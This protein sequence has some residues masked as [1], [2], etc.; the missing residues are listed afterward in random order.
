MPSARNNPENPIKPGFIG[1]SPDNGAVLR[2]CLTVCPEC[3]QKMEGFL[4]LE[5]DGIYLRRNCERHGIT[6]ISLSSNPAGYAELDRFYFRTL[7]KG[8]TSG[9]I[10]NYWILSTSRCQMMCDYCQVNVREPAFEE[11]DGTDLNRVIT[12][13]P[14]IKLTMSGGEPTLHPD[15]LRFFRDGAL[16]GG[17]TQLATNG[18]ALADHAFCSRLKAAGAKEVRLSV[19]S[20]SPVPESST[21]ASFNKYIP[22]KMLALKNLEETGFSVSLSPTIFKGVNEA[23]LT[24]ALRYAADRPF[25]KEISVNGFSWTGA[26]VS[27]SREE[28]M[29]PDYMMDVICA[30][31]G[32]SDRESVFTLQKALFAALH[33]MG[34][35]LCMYTQIM[36][37]VRKA[38]RLEPILDYFDMKRMKAALNSWERLRNAVYP[39]RFAAFILAM[40]Y[41]MKPR[42]LLLAGDISKIV[43]ANYFRMDFS[44]YPGSLLPVVLNTNCSPLTAD[45]EVSRQ[46]MSAIIYKKGGELK[47]AVTTYMLA[48]F[49]PRG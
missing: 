27:R 46:C 48:G 8:E 41:S 22:Q 25:I 19:E 26:G 11:M 42:T 3:L 7:K 9:R 21:L 49:E 6:E 15:M 1:A 29:P 39:V 5:K 10:T 36:I 37:F 34:I 14:E 16:S 40:L 47:K 38:G 30:G 24:D 17:C 2:K 20:F 33:L 18:L 31:A 45:E 32:I 12:E 23:A 43:L 13:N 35:R 28:M 4:M 44:K